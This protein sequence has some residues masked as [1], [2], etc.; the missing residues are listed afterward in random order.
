MK[1]LF[2]TSVLVAAFVISHPKH[3]VCF[4]WLKSA[5]SRKIQGFI[6]THSLAETYSVITRLPIQPRLTPEQAQQIILD[7]SQ[8]LEAIPLLSNDYQTA[9]AQMAH[10]NLP[11]GGI[12]DALIAQAAIK[13]KV[14]VL[15]TLNPNHF[16]RLGDELAKL[17]QVPE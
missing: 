1:V 11:G 14:D 13:A 15:L 12:F 5:E 4:S 16:N 17:V 6:S 9:I 8:Y 2:D 3:S 7:I 10:L